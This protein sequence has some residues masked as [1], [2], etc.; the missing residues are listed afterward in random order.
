MPVPRAKRQANDKWD[1][2]NMKH[3]ACKIKKED[4]EAFKAY[5]TENRTTPNALLR[6]FI[7]R[8]IG[9]KEQGEP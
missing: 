2:E 7:Y 5:A 6:K 3:V 1:S 8:C 4:A 9:K